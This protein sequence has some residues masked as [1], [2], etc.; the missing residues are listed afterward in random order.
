[1]LSS[2]VRQKS[3]GPRSIYKQMTMYFYMYVS[4]S[5]HSFLRHI[6]LNKKEKK[7]KKKHLFVCLEKSY[8]GDERLAEKASNSYK[9]F[10]LFFVFIKK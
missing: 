1:M 6:S 3:I 10:F 5:G 7:R 2:C 9:Y 4:G 8:Q